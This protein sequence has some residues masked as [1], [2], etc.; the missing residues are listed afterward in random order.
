MMDIL[1]R[2]LESLRA[3]ERQVSN[4][5]R[6]VRQRG[7]LELSKYDRDISREQR[8]LKTAQQ[9]IVV[10]RTA[11]I[12]KP[13]E[14]QRHHEFIEQRYTEAAE[15]Y[16]HHI[17]FWKNAASLGASVCSRAIEVLD[18][19]LTKLRSHIQSLESVR[20]MDKEINKILFLVH[21]IDDEISSEII[22]PQLVPENSVEANSV[23][24]APEDE[25]FFVSNHDLL[26]G[27][28]VFVD[29]SDDDE[30]CVPYTPPSDSEERPRK[31][32][33]QNNDSKSP[34]DSTPPSKSPRIRKTRR[35][36]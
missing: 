21:T 16:E 3:A 4:K 23:V 12:G 9:M 28:Y 1:N 8:Q 26:G 20:T 29:P 24:P 18:A 27:D 19:D 31:V 22:D 7:A 10:H 5:I 17:K 32:S 36:D 11:A 13:S 6:I 33:R 35:H 2:H 14:I 30:D 25:Q 15:L 34:S